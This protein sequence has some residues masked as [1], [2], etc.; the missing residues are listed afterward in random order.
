MDG[1]IPYVPQTKKDRSKPRKDK[2]IMVDEDV[3]ARQFS[4]NNILKEYL[5]SQV[6]GSN[7]E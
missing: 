6:G 4:P 1:F 2:H 5:D 3:V 7:V